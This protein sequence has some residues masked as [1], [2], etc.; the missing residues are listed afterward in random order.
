MHAAFLGHFKI[1]E[2]LVDNGANLSTEDKQGFTALALALAKDRQMIVKFLR[3][4]G[5][6]K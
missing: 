6:A 2:I 5:A 4:R 3:D 1:V